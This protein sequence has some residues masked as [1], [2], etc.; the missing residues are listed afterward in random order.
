MLDPDDDPLSLW[1]AAR[2][3]RKRPA[4]TRDS[5]PLTLSLHRPLFENSAQLVV[6]WD[7]RTWQPV[8]VTTS[9]AEAYPLI[10]RRGATPAA[11]QEDTPVP[12]LRKG[13]GRHRRP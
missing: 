6:E 13:P 7:G 3:D 8:A 1:Y 5:L 4:G 10:V 12:L 9:Y 2:A 11:P